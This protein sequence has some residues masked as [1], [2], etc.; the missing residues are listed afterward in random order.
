MRSALAALSAIPLV[1]LRGALAPVVVKNHAASPSRSS[2]RTAASD[3][4]IPWTS[5]DRSRI[6]AGTLVFVHPGELR[7]A[8]WQEFTLDGDELQWRVPAERI[9]TR[10]QHIVPLSSQA[11]AIHNELLPSTA[12]QATSSRPCAI[13][14]DR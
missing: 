5:G 4:R 10:E 11:V 2:W 3:R 13:P 9:K 6:Q 8:K 7:R 14:T 12:T 1:D